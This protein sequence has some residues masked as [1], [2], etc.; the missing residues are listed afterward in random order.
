MSIEEEEDIDIFDFKK[1]QHLQENDPKDTVEDQVMK[2][3][4]EED[5]EE[6]EHEEEEITEE[7]V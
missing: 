1:E 6:S 2:S 4:N 5:R 7:R 3:M